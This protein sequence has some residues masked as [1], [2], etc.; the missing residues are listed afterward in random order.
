MSSWSSSRLEWSIGRE[1][2]IFSKSKNKWFKGIIINIFNDEQGEW[3]KVKYGKNKN[4]KKE[5]QRYSKDIREIK[6]YSTNKAPQQQ[7][8][9]EHGPHKKEKK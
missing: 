4:K 8:Q 9:K 3:L 7:Q 6:N 5:I 2:E 1:I